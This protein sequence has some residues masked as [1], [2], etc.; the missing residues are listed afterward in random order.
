MSIAVRGAW[1]RVV[2]FVGFR[3]RARPRQNPGQRPSRSVQYTEELVMRRR[4]IVVV[5]NPIGVLRR[6]SMARRH[7]AFLF[8]WCLSLFVFPVHAQ[9]R[10]GLQGT[11]KDTGGGVIPGA[12]VTVINQE[13]N[14]A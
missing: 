10:A 8:C 4:A 1:A 6:P 7:C 11:I 13:T 2:F 5:A 9:F 3:G 14:V 12:E